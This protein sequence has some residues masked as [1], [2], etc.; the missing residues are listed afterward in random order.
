MTPSQAA[1]IIGCSAGHV[2]W[3]IRHE[4]IDATYQV[5]YVGTETG[6]QLGA[7]DIPEE[8]VERVRIEWE[9]TD[10]KRGPK[11]GAKA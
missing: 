6:Y 1:K 4:K 8:E 2:R 10:N 3:L 9:K 11:R 7:W 5:I